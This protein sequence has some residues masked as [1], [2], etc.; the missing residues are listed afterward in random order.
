[1]SDKIRNYI[2]FDEK[3]WRKEKKLKDR[4][5]V[6]LMSSSSKAFLLVL[7]AR[8]AGYNL[9]LVKR[10]MPRGEKAEAK[11]QLARVAKMIGAS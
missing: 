9:A 8:V 1:M 2:P 10:D 3:A 6:P 11:R 4:I 7:K 5:L